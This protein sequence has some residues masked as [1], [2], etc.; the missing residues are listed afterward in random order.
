MY[1]V[2]TS[3]ASKSSKCHRA[4]RSTVDDDDDDDEFHKKVNENKIK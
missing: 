4:F 1:K 3:L 2:N